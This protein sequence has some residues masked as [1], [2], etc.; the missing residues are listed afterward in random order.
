MDLNK[1]YLINEVAKQFNISTNKLRFYE[2]KGMIQPKRDDENNYRYYTESDLIKLQA[3]LLYRLL[4]M[5][6]K[7]IKNIINDNCSHNMLEHFNKQWLAVNDEIHRMALIRDSLE[8][9]MDSIYDSDNNELQERIHSSIE[10]MGKIYEI[11]ENWRD[12]WGFDSWAKT[13]D[14][15]VEEDISSTKMYRKYDD[16]LNKVYTLATKNIKTN[17]KILDI[18]VGTGNLSKRFL[19]NGYSNIIGLDQSREMIHVAKSKFPNLKLRL[20]EFLKIPFENSVFDL[21]VSTYAFHHLSEEEKPVA[22]KEM[23]RVLKDNGKIVIGDLMFKSEEDKKEIYKNLSKGQISEI[24]D[25]YYSNIKILKDEC[26]KYNKDLCA[27]KIDTLVFV[28]EIQ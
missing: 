8:G 24:E 19:E 22:I 4:N 18:G 13:Y 28:I 16:V 11:K 27:Y 15:S 14:I 6:I 23:L 20:G 7:D 21:I 25:E 17:S 3:I 9:I 12:R 5:P 1:R 10:N 2:K 26:T